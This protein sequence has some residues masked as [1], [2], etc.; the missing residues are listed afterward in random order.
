MVTIIAIGAGNRSNTYM[1]YA[2]THPD[3]LR[4]VGV[5]E[6]NPYRRKVVQTKFDLPEESCHSNWSEFLEL[7]KMCDAVII[8][9]TDDMHY[10][11]AIKAIERGYNILLE[12]PIA[13]SVQ[14][15]EDIANAA[16]RKGVVVGVCHVLRYHPFFEK[17][18]ELLDEKVCGEI[19]NIR[20][21]E[22]VGIER[23]THAY[24]R[25]LWKSKEETNPLVLSKSCHDIDLLVWMTSGRCKMICSMGS[26][27]WFKPEN[28]PEG[29]AT[30]CVDCPSHIEKNCPY[31]AV[32]L[33]VRR[34]M[35]H[36][37]FDVGENATDE[38]IRKVLETEDYGRC[39]YFAGN[40]VVDHQSSIM[41]ME[42]GVTVD[43]TINGITKDSHRSTHIM[44]S[45]GE[46]IG[47]E[48]K[49]IHN[50]YVTGE[51]KVYD[52]SEVAKLPYHAGADLALVADFVR[53]V[54]EKDFDFRVAIKHSLQSHKIAF[55]A[56]QSRV[57]KRVIFVE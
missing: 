51:R 17:L 31:S 26:L 37:H 24:V 6:P 34:R 47:N 9:T 8:G 16:A 48:S 1:E 46:L 20:H 41:E 28:A 49:L 7:P 40:D 22:A 52:F 23:M 50:D 2:Y 45:K 57:E 56:E 29:C 43:F 18:K 27:R 10:E 53:A 13:Q 11:P 38:D 54:E 36:R 3:K 44:G 19:I 14:Q 25:G 35:W 12:K 5:V 30:R 4:V 32:N 15:C 42:G 33:Y 21:E 39:V 55:Y